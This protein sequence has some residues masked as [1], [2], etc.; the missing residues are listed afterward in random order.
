MEVTHKKVNHLLLGVTGGIASGKSTV[1]NMLKDLGA[2]AIDLDILAREVVEPG[3]QALQ[4]IVEYFGNGVLKEDGNLDRKKLSDIVFEDTGKR[5]KLESFTHHRITKLFNQ[6]LKDITAEDPDAI[7]Q[8]VNPL[9]I[10]FNT[11]YRYHKTLVVYVPRETQIERLV[12]RDNIPKGKAE[13]ILDA[14]MP[15]DEKIGYA[16]FIVYNDKS[17]D[18][19]K[20]QV[21]GLWEKLK[22]IQNQKAGQ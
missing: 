21:Q 5:K 2:Y 16:D 22:E 9:L 3:Q 19:T 13:K 6:K 12:K 18:E 15:I 1:A 7:I 11:Q 4:E 20:A 10:E 17:L 8:V 14:Q